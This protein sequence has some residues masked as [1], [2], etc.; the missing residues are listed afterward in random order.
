M[1]PNHTLFFTKPL[2]HPFISFLLTTTLPIPL[3]FSPLPLFLYQ[4]IIPLF[5]TQINPLL[6]QHL[7]N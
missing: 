4:R 5:P 3:I 6:P 2:M 1:P 7:I